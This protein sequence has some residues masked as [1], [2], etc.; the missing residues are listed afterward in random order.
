ME[1][2]IDI[3][4]SNVVFGLYDNL[5]WAKVWRMPTISGDEMKMYYQKQL[6][7]EL[8]ENKIN[9]PDV[10]AI[11]VSSVVP[12]LNQNFAKILETLFGFEPIFISHDSYKNLQIATD[13][14]AEMGTDLIAN[15]VAAV[16]I[17]QDNSIIVD[18]GTALTFTTVTSEF[19]ILG[20][21]IA[22]GLFTAFKSLHGGTA[23]LPEVGPK[24]PDSVIGKNTTEAIQA[25][26]CWGYIGLIKSIVNQIESELETS[27]VKIAT[28]GL[29]GVLSPLDGFFNHVEPYLTLDG[30]RIIGQNH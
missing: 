18:F 28:G 20:V 21:S 23:Q 15:A 30:I 25:G 9:I 24:L 10:K 5:K 26:V 12:H 2:I 7:H 14:P 8:L 3:G 22:P 4:N 17:F 29:S 6:I 11:Y 19:K 27:F 16:N 1:L 13:V